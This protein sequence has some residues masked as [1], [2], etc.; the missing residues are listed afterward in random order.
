MAPKS[1]VPERFRRFGDRDKKSATRK[2]GTQGCKVYFKVDVKRSQMKNRMKGV[3]ERNPS[4]SAITTRG[5]GS[6]REKFQP[7]RP[8]SGSR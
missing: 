1:S 7:L 8:A 2:D 4:R 6:A 3:D 5:D